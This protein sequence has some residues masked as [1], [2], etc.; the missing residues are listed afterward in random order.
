MTKLSPLLICYVLICSNCLDTRLNVY[1]LSPIIV[2]GENVGVILGPYNT[3]YSGLKQ[4]LSTVPFLFNAES[5]GCWNNF[6]DLDSDKGIPT[7]H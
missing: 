4:Q 2:S 7:L 3:K 1:T 6:L 5:Q